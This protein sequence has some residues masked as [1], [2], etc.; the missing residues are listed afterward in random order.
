MPT[1]RIRR[2]TARRPRTV[3]GQINQATGVSR[4][5]SVTRAQRRQWRSN[6]R[7]ALTPVQRI[8]NLTGTRDAKG[9]YIGQKRYDSLDKVQAKYRDGAA[10]I[11]GRNGKIVG[12]MANYA[13]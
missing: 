3:Q 7:R 12:Y 4:Q 6:A 9:W 5:T 10:A 11:Y 8:E 1:S 13:T 2:R